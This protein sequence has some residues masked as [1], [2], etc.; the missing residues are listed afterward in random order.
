MMFSNRCKCYKDGWG[1]EMLQTSFDESVIQSKRPQT[2]ERER[3][4]RRVCNSVE[5]T[6]DGREREREKRDESVIQSKRPDGGERSGDLV[7]RYHR[8][9]SAGQDFITAGNQGTT[10]KCKPYTA[11]IF[12]TQPRLRD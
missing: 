2:R 6:T 10:F 4:R 3:E 5:E 11:F 8:A 1:I 12:S 9:R 7:S